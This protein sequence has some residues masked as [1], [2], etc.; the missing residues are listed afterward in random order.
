MK[1]KH[2]S[3]N[4]EDAVNILSE[5]LQKDSLWADAYYFRALCYSALGRQ[6]EAILDYDSV[7]KYLF[8]RHLSEHTML[9][10]KP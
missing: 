9:R 6:N 1:E 4:Y 10:W 5:E 2:R 3:G 7:L 8:V